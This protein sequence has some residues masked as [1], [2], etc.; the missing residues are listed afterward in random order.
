MPSHHPLSTWYRY[1]RPHMA[2]TL[3]LSLPVMV[4]QLGFVLMGVT[5]TL[6][7][8]QLGKVYLSASSL[9]NGFYFILTIFGMG[10]TFAIAPLVSEMN[11]AGKKADAGEYLRQGMWVT[12]A[13]GVLIM[14]LSLLSAELLAHPRL[15]QPVEEVPYARSYLRIV[16][17]SV[18][19][20]LVFLAFKGF[21]D[22]LGY[23]RPGMVFTLIGLVV[24]GTA[25]LLL[26]FGLLG[27]PELKLD[28]AAYATLGARTFMAVGMG[29]FVLQAGLFKDFKLRTGWLTFRW[30]P[31]RKVLA[32]GIPS[33]LQYFF[34]VGA[35][36]GAVVMIGWLGTAPRAAHQ[37]VLTLA[38]VTYM[39]ATGIASGGSIRVAHFMGARQYGK[40]QAAGWTAVWLTLGFMTLA[41]VVFLLGKDL[42]PSL[43]VP[44][45]DVVAMASGL[46]LIAAV[47]QIFDGVQAVGIANLRGV[48]DVWIPTLIAF[49]SYWLISL[50]VGY[51]F[52]FPLDQGVIGVWYGFV[53]GLFTAA[54]ALT[55]R[56]HRLTGRWIRES[57]PSGP[58][59][60]Q[61]VTGTVA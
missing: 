47:F 17:V 4:G 12:V 22:G 54:A 6:M 7:V 3:H 24:N 15:N 55:F 42:I 46:M 19:P 51:V 29:I 1:F 56:F 35:F 57:R 11:G 34:E 36:M 59:V 16:S 14:L 37:A 44:D 48:Q 20:M 49:V 13:F 18:I 38:S 31:A 33:G 9:A 23:T 25:N 21:A 41:A 58:P 27:F 5:D 60:E 40:V 2:Q 43:I 10:I 50:P 52:G 28:G 53:A 26:I 39:V 45:A 32:L 30:G 8:G 61:P